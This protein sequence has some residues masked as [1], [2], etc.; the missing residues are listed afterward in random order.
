MRVELTFRAAGLSAVEIRQ[1]V[2]QVENSSF[3]T[4]DSWD[5][6]L[7]VRRVP[8]VESEVLVVRGTRLLCGA[9]GNCQVWVFRRAGKQWRSTFEKDAPL[10][11]GLG[12]T[13]R[14]TAGLNDL[15]LVSSLGG[16]KDRYTHY[17]FDGKFYRRAE[18]FDV[19]A[20]EGPAADTGVQKITCE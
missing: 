7:R 1:V 9:T 15:L 14:T 5:E 16:D 13:D 4:P 19:T 3:D 6:E 17:R 8:W 2:A 12:F 20:S 18:C 11:S 10:A